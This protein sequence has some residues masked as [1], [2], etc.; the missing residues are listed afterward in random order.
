M[1]LEQGHAVNGGETLVH[2]GNVQQ[3]VV[4]QTHGPVNI[5]SIINQLLD[6][7]AKQRPSRRNASQ[8]QPHATTPSDPAYATNRSD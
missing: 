5:H 6:A 2:H 4:Q 1:M 7:T 8:Q 3:H